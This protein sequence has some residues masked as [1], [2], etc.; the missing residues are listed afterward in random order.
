MLIQPP[1]RNLNHGFSLIEVMIAMLLA[2]VGLLGL[3]AAQLKSLQYASSS[4]HYNMALVQG[5]NAIER[6]W[7]DTQYLF[8]GDKLFD[9][10]YIDGLSTIDG[11]SLQIDTGVPNQL[12]INFAVV[13]EWN[14]A[15]MTDASANSVSVEAAF[16]N[17]DGVA[18]C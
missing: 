14:D 15:R 6:I 1:L 5:N 8:N 4:F 12:C 13:V 2:A 7:T 16:P 3:A 18:G 11:Y 17:L 9:Q 10:T